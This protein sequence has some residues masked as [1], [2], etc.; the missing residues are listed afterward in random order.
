MVL[1]TYII[2]KV[3]NKTL[4]LIA[5]EFSPNYTPSMKYLLFSISLV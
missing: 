2:K 3:G 4:M 1:F 5:F